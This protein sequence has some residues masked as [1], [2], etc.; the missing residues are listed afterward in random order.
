MNGC[1]L[2]ADEHSATYAYAK[3]SSI[4]HIYVITIWQLV[5]AREFYKFKRNNSRS[6]YHSLHF[7]YAWRKLNDFQYCVVFDFVGTL[8]PHSNYTIYVM[9]RTFVTNAAKNC[10]IQKRNC[11]EDELN[12]CT[13]CQNL[14]NCSPIAY[15]YIVASVLNEQP[16]G[17]AA[18]YQIH[19]HTRSFKKLWVRWAPLHANFAFVVPLEFFAQ[20]QQRNHSNL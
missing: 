4:W 8:Y 19:T 15:I 10:Y 16:P 14:T 11:Y 17:S 20:T 3:W 1:T 5:A 7:V 9:A 6:S 2:T 13:R 12:I 18:A